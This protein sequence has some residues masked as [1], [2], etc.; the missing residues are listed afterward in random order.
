MCADR[1]RCVLC[2]FLYLFKLRYCLFSH[3]QIHREP[4]Q[5]AWQSS[6]NKVAHS[7][8]RALF[9]GLLRF[10]RNDKGGVGAHNKGG[11]CVAHDKRGAEK[12]PNGAFVI[13]G[14]R[15]RFARY[16]LIYMRSMYNQTMIVYQYSMSGLQIVHSD[17]NACMI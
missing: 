6:Y 12:R 3:T 8:V 10:T 14:H 16:S 15:H 11:P 7:R 4:S 17:Q 2:V 1:T 13:P 9:T 5:M